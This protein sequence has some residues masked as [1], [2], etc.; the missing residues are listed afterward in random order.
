MCYRL[1]AELSQRIAA[2]APVSGTIAVEE[3]QPRRPVSVMHFHGT[4][5]KLVPF[6][7][8]SER[9]AKFLAFKSVEETIRTWVRIDGCPRTPKTTDL[10]HKADDGTTVKREIMDRARTG[11]RSSY[12][13]SRVVA[14][15]GLVEVAH[16]LAGQDDPQHFGQRSDVGVLQAASDEVANLS[17]HAEHIEEATLADIH[18][19]WPTSQFPS[20]CG[21]VKE[22]RADGLP[23]RHVTKH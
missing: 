16:S 1:A 19:N 18:G 5:D 23:P 15:P 11:P 2:I 17:L 10:P 12:S 9:T 6:N 3:R 8:P 22:I 4:A 14:R 21:R 20:C 7:G 13:S